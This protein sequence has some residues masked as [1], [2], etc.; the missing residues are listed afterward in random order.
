MGRRIAGLSVGFL[1]CLVT[2]AMAQDAATIDEAFKNGK[3]SGEI[4]MYFESTDKDAA[5]ADTGWATSYFTLKYVTQPWNDLTLG[6]RFFA[7]G[8]VYSDAD[9]PGVDPYSIDIEKKVT[10]PELYLNYSFGD[11]GSGITA[12]SVD[13][14]SG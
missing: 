12:G 7:H 9:T 13:L 4:G 2:G 5:G 1:L 6:T 8:D 14:A 3:I 11:A 10:L